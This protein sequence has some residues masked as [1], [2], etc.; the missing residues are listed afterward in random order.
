MQDLAWVHATSGAWGACTDVA[1]IA[2]QKLTPQ[3]SVAYAGRKPPQAPR[4]TTLLVAPKAALGAPPN[5]PLH[6]NRW[7]GGKIRDTPSHTRMRA[8]LQRR[9]LSLLD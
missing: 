1:A 2:S 7:R 4:V 6:I 5:L 9:G 3:D 8:S